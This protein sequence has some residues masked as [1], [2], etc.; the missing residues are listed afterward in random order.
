MVKELIA[1]HYAGVT[2]Y[3]TSSFL[4]AKLGKALAERSVAPHIYES[5]A[6]ARAYLH[7]LGAGS[8]SADG[9]KP[10]LST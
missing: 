2:R 4:R 3:T 1:R 5:A 10:A 8:A 9:T 6:E 7:S